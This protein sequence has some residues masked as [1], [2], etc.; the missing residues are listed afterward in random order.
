MVVSGL[1]LRDG[2][3]EQRLQD[4]SLED[5]VSVPRSS[6]PPSDLLWPVEHCKHG[7]GTAGLALWPSR[8]PP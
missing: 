7:T 6:L 1:N 3:S 4:W 2:R 8:D 5:Q